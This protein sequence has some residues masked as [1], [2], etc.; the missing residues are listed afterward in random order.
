MC[1]GFLN[2]TECETIF[3]SNLDSFHSQF[4]VCTG[5]S[6]VGGAGKGKRDLRRSEPS[7]EFRLQVDHITPQKLKIVS[8]TAIPINQHLLREWV[9]YLMRTS[10]AEN[11]HC[12]TISPQREPPPS[13]VPPEGDM[14]IAPRSKR[15]FLSGPS[16]SAGVTPH[17]IT[18]S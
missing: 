17:S 5:F 10:Q 11:K 8:G 9:R 1:F 13:K 18:W 6:D 4:V 7:P 2:P 12:F 16:R 15:E 14:T 3:R